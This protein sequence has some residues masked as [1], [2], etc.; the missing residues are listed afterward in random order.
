[1]NMRRAS[2]WNV[3]PSARLIIALGMLVDNAIVIVDGML[4]THRA[5]DEESR[6]RR[7]ISSSTTSWPLLG[8]TIIAV[9]AFASI[10]TSDD[11][12]GEY[13]RSLVYRDPYFIAAELGHGCHGH[14]TA[15]RHVP[16]G[17]MTAVPA[18]GRSKRPLRRQ[19]S[20]RNSAASLAVVYVVRWV[21]MAGRWRHCLHGIAVLAFGNLEQSFFPNSTRPQFMVDYWLPQ[22]HAASTGPT[23]DVETIENYIR[24]GIEGVT[25]VTSLV[26]QG[27]PRFLLTYSH[28]RS[29]N[30]AYAQL[31]VD[32]EDSG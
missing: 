6:C 3:S 9:L 14:A 20:T 12:T 25:H 27:A 19:A 30:S 22:G 21:T 1:M 10:G 17:P 31:L 28:R 5:R 24:R 16:Q 32:V 11:S 15:G 13:T 2:C 18:E 8:A 29:S 7:S 4:D 23:R 26:G